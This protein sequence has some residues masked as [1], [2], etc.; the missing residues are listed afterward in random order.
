MLKDF[1]IFNDSHKYEVLFIVRLLKPRIFLTEE[2]VVTQGDFGSELYL[3]SLGSCNVYQK[4]KLKNLKKI[5]RN[6]LQ[7]KIISIKKKNPKAHNYIN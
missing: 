5:I 4:M 6:N 3:I 1:E 2:K 7:E